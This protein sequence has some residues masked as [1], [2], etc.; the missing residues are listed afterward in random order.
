MSK[1]GEGKLD[2]LLRI[3]GQ[4]ELPLD[5]RLGTSERW[6]LSRNA[7]RDRLAYIYCRQANRVQNLWRKSVLSCGNGCQQVIGA[8]GSAF[9]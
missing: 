8:D 1:F 5:W 3:I 7:V 2:S 6:R 9:E 4:R